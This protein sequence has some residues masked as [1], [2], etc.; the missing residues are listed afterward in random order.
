MAACEEESWLEDYNRDEN[1]YNAS[2]GAH[3]NLKRAERARVTVNKLPALVDSLVAKARAWE[4]ERGSPFLYDGMRLLEMLEEYNLLRQEKE[5]E[6]RRARDQKRLQEQFMT[7]QETL[8][9]SRPSPNKPLSGKKS[10]GLRSNGSSIP[11][12]DIAATRRLSLA[13]GGIQSGNA[14]M[15]VPRVNGVTPVRLGKDGKRE[16]ARPVAPVNY[17]AL[18]KEDALSISSVNGSEP[19]S[20][21][22]V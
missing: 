21:M 16:R 12:G 15:L 10:L 3:L 1:R 22:A 9:G 19:T 8:F 20:P 5:E 7:E 18:P 2:R 6:K 13:G 17:V 14:D 4:E 11:A